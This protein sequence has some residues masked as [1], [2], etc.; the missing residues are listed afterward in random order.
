MKKIKRFLPMLLAL[1]LALSLAACGSNSPEPAVE[2]PDNKP[3]TTGNEEAKPQGDPVKLSYWTNSRHDSEFIQEKIDHFNKTNTSNIEVEMTVMADNYVQ[4]LDLAFTSNQSPDIFAY[5]SREHYLK[6]Y[7]EPLNAYLEDDIKEKFSGSIKEGV[8]MF[9]GN[10]I[11]LGNFGTTIRLVYNAD[12]FEQLNLQPPKTLDE[13]VETA[14]KITEYGKKDGLY[15]WAMN[16]K[17]PAGALS[18]SMGA[19]ASVEGMPNG[20]NFKEARYNFAGWEPIVEAFR[21]MYTDGSTLPGAE[22]LDIDPLR[23]QFAEGKIGMYI[24]YSYEPGVYKDQ[25]PPKI[26]WAATQVPAID[27]TES[28]GI[29]NMGGLSWIGMSS[30][31]EHKKEGWE[32]MKFMYSDELLREYHENGYGLS[33]LPHVLNG[34]KV[35]DIAGMEYFIP[36]KFDG[37]WPVQPSIT[38]EGKAVWDEFMKYILVG[39]DFQ[40]IVTDLNTRYNAALDKAIQDGTTTAE[41]DPSFDPRSFQIEK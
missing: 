3:Q 34:A 36:T 40:S 35:P 22:S 21:Q 39:G 37:N 13:M 31:S 24:S 41:P 14:K 6:E 2:K 26:N 28:E 29:I 20:Y 5:P 17:N 12:V 27:E 4:S 7:V 38:L 11:S 8:N 9:E 16:Y 33:V 1:V 30:K 23:A 32:F 15:G 19:I 25:F 10:I 18:R